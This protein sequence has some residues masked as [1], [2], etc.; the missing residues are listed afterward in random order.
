MPKNQN[1]NAAIRSLVAQEVHAVLEPH[2]AILERLTAFLE[3][4]SKTQRRAGRPRKA[5]KATGRRPAHR[6][7]KKLAKLAK[8]F[9]V[10]QAVTYKQG[11]G[12][13]DAK[14]LKIDVE[15]GL[16][17]VRR[18]K[19]G[20]KV[21]RPAFKVTPA[22]AKA[23][24][25]VS[26]KPAAKAR[27]AGRRKAKAPVATVNMKIAKR[28]AEGQVVRFK[29]GRGLLDAKVVGIDAEKGALTLQQVK[30]GRKVVRAASNVMAIG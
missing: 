22:A 10:G 25:K 30:D 17:T 7:G 14:V 4:E 13:F 16:L 11:R 15:A 2:R 6:G 29:Q 5:L 19:D 1:I 12:T 24:A 18:I 8:N 28:F 3:S 27:R 23:L 20:K 9:S 21:A 26:R